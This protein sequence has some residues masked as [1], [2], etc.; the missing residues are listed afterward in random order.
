MPLSTELTISYPH[1]SSIGYSSPEECF[2]K[3]TAAPHRTGPYICNAMLSDG[4]VPNEWR[5]G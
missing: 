2:F 1:G 5:E 3:L 4:R